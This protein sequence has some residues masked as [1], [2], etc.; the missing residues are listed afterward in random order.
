MATTIVP[1]RGWREKSI[2]G[3]GDNRPSANGSIL[4]GAVVGA[5]ALA[6]A[7]RD[8]DDRDVLRLLR[9]PAASSHAGRSR[10]ARTVNTR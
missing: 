7:R 4:L 1:T 2:E 9:L 3:M 8:D 10:R 6:A 5:G